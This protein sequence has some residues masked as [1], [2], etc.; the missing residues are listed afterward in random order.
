MRN[1]V[2]PY[3]AAPFNHRYETRNGGAFNFT[4]GQGRY[5]QHA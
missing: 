1:S 2:Y 4:T 3:Q 5:L